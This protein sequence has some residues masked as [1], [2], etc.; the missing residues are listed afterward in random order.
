MR[1][2]PPLPQE[3]WDQIPPHLQAT[4]W[5]MV[6]GYERRIAALEVEVGELK[7]EI[8]GLKEQ[9]GQNSQNS[10]RPPSSDGLQVKRKP[11]R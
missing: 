8:Q 1:R 3:V 4:I 10:S 11:P 2:E 6:E 5:I 7:G 9:L